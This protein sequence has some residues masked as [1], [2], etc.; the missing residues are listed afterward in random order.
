MGQKIPRKLS[1]S[2]IVPATVSVGRLLDL[3]L[4]DHAGEYAAVRE[5]LRM[6]RDQQGGVGVLPVPGGIAHAVGAHATL[7]RG[8]GKHL[9]TGTHAE[10]IGAFPVGQM[11]V[12][13]VIRRRQLSP[14]SSVLGKVDIRLPVLNAHTHGKRLLLHGHALG[15]KMFK[16]VPGGVTDGQYQPVAGQGVDAVSVPDLRPGQPAFFYNKMLQAV[17]KAHFP[18]QR[19]HAAADVLHHVN[20][21]V[22]ADVGLRVIQNVFRRAVGGKLGEHP[23]HALVVGAGIQLPVGKGTGSPLAELHIALRVQLTNRAEPVHR[24]LTAE[25]V[26]PPLDDDGPGACPGQYQRGEHPRRAKTHHHRTKHRRLYP[27]DSVFNLFVFAHVRAFCPGDDFFF[28]SA[29]LYGA[30]A[31]IMDVV[32]FPGVQ[33]TLGEMKPGNL[34]FFYPQFFCGKAF[35]LF[36]RLTGKEPYVSHKDHFPSLPA[37]RPLAQAHWRL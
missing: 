20:E 26:L 15:M 10:G 27:G 37:S 2:Q 17:F 30:G 36:R 29:H 5:I 28:V 19:N 22:G 3:P 18:A 9:P 23:A 34:S 4:P 24:R 6:E 8:G 32:L 1:R 33:R 21:N 12:Q 31:D 16:G 25:G 13:G 11:D 35:Q 7:L 14:R